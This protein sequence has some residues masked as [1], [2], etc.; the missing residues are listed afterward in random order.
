MSIMCVVHS[1]LCSSCVSQHQKITH[2]CMPST[3][4]SVRA[5]GDKLSTAL[6]LLRTRFTTVSLAS[7][8]RERAR[9]F[10]PMF[11]FCTKVANR[12]KTQQTKQ[13][14]L[15][16][17]THAW[18]IGCCWWATRA[19]RASGNHLKLRAFV[20]QSCVYY[21]HHS[22]RVLRVVVTQ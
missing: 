3:H 1:L 19:L 7:V 11:L 17:H 13:M 18:H 21:H 8:T 12:K 14:Y 2:L 16:C 6:S 22:L 5:D 9:C 15:L 10:V 20:Q 4:T